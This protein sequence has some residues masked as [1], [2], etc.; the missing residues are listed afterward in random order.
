[1]NKSCYN[2]IRNFGNK[3]S[4][5][6]GGCQEARFLVPGLTVM[7]QFFYAISLE[8]IFYTDTDEWDWRPFQ[9]FSLGFLALRIFITEGHQKKKNNNTP[10]FMT[11]L[12]NL[13]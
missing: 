4:T 2:C 9:Q 11:H 7:V 5:V 1:M 8:D 12:F 13:P 3:I 10:T 6:A